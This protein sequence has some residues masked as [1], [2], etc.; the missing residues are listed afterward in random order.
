MEEEKIVTERKFFLLLKI[1][2]TAKRHFFKRRTYSLDPFYQH[3]QAW[4]VLRT[5][6]MNLLWFLCVL[7]PSVWCRGHCK[8]SSLVIYF[9]R[10]KNIKSL[11]FLYQHSLPTIRRG[12]FIFFSNIC[13]KEI[14]TLNI[15]F[16]QKVV[17]ENFSDNVLKTQRKNIFFNVFEYLNINWKI[18]SLVKIYV[19]V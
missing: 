2:M 1:S 11:H 7:V 9:R 13:Q 12:A 16:L 15:K 18:Y 3:Y 6:W 17:N 8:Q 10:K 19:T 4:S 5:L 14:I